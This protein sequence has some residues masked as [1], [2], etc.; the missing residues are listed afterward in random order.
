MSC[1]SVLLEPKVPDTSL[2]PPLTF[3][4]EPALR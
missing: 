3:L 1:V 2:S 4:P